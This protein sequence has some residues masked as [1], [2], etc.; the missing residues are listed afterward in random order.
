[1]IRS[2]E[3]SGVALLRL[4]GPL[5]D[6]YLDFVSSR[7]RPNTVLA[8]A[9]DLKVFYTVVDKPVDEVTSADGLAFITA[10]RTGADSRGLRVVDAS[11][12][13]SARARCGGGCQVSR[14]CSGICTRVAM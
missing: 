13:V 3:A 11:A 2:A 4:G 1:V 6:G 7:C 14:G 9:I 10:Q 12:G 8:T 5:L